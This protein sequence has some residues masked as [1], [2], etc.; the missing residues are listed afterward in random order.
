MLPALLL[1]NK[2]KKE[3]DLF[4]F[5][6]FCAFV[7]VLFGLDVVQISGRNLEREKPIRNM[8]AQ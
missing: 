4:I 2:Q 1:G 5:S 8:H 6:I 3:K 7:F